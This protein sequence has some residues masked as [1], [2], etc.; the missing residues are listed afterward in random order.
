MWTLIGPIHVP[1]AHCEVISR[2]QNE[3]TWS[4]VCT[5][6]QQENALRLPGS[7]LVRSAPDMF[8]LLIMSPASRYRCRSS[9]A[10]SPACP[11]CTPY[12]RMRPLRASRPAVR[13]ALDD[14]M[15]SRGSCRLACCRHAETISQLV[16]ACIQIRAECSAVRAAQVTEGTYRWSRTSSSPADM[17]TACTFIAWNAIVTCSH[18]CSEDLCTCD[19]GCIA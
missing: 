14:V 17:M 10:G 4:T 11:A 3:L 1:K 12:D 6:R 9:F 18:M 15:H 13:Q 19:A 7:R 2:Q 16:P 8:F 5:D